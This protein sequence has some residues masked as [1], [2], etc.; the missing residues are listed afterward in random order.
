MNESNSSI[1]VVISVAST[2]KNIY[3]QSSPTPPARFYS[4]VPYRFLSLGKM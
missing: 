3:I 2:E 4:L 1:N